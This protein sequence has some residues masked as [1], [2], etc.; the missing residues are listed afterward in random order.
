MSGRDD[1]W[2]GG[3]DTKADRDESRTERP[4][5]NDPSADRPTVD[6]QDERQREASSPEP[7]RGGGAEPP[8]SPDGPP[9]ER[10][11][12]WSALLLSLAVIAVGT[13]GAIY[14]AHGVPR[15][16]AGAAIL[17]AGLGAGGVAGRTAAPSI[18]AHLD[19]AWR[20][21]RPYVWLSAGLFA[22]GIA[23]GLALYAAGVDLTDLLLEAL[24]EEFGEDELPGDGADPG[25]GL[26]FEPT[27]GF[28][29]ANNTP[30]FL[31]AI[32]GAL[33][34]GVVTLIL[35]V[36][37][38][39]LI[40]NIAAVVGSETG[41]GVIVALIGPHGIFEL[42]ALFI[43][44]GV[45]FRFVHRAG[46]RVFGSRGALF[47]KAYLLRT[48]LFVVFGWLLLVLAAFVEAYVT[49]LIADTLV[50]M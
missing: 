6:L 18:L 28:F 32:A 22:V 13:A 11:R 44:A 16:A 23:I 27:A 36:F 2:T 12:L 17:G 15:A 7:N 38:G 46:Q 43:A 25:G 1:D 21:H 9:S 48:T 42:P 30:P 29:I 19:E 31:A 10:L 50:P 34:L 35:M 39:L 47:T 26:A 37:N 24:T 5:R 40:G 4:G 33:T 45:G 41:L 8:H 14:V 49:L 3:T 20:E